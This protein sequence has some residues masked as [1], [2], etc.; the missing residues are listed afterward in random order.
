MK[1][2]ITGAGG[3]V[4]K[5]LQQHLAERK[6]VEVVCFTRANTVAELPRLLDG[7]EFVFHLAGVNRPQDPQEFVTGNADLTAA[8]VAAVEGEMRASGRRIA[9]VCSSS[10]QAARD[11]P[12]GASKRAAEDV[13]RA[14][15]EEFAQIGIARL[16]DAQ[17]FVGLAGLVAPRDE[18]EIGGDVA[19]APREGGGTIARVTVPCAD[20]EA[21]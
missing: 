16:A 17:L 12:Y 3:F 4:G 19:L 10:T 13:L 5:N 11:N 15:D 6:D 18:S 20:P 14:A 9:I 21:R 7:V 8:L 1:V 2:L